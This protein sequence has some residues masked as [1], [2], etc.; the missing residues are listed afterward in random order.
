MENKPFTSMIY[1]LPQKKCDFPELR[2]GSWAELV[3]V[4]NSAGPF[5]LADKQVRFCSDHEVSTVEHRQNIHIYTVCLHV[6][7][8]I[9]NVYIYIKYI[10]ICIYTQSI[11][12]RYIHVQHHIKLLCVST[13]ASPSTCHSPDLL[14]EVAVNLQGR[15]SRLRCTSSKKILGRIGSGK[16]LVVKNSINCGQ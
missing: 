5:F 16:L 7:I 6:H 13:I 4:P 14:K 15:L 12:C 1:A 9:Y 3:R 10:Y 11:L 2:Q 8:E